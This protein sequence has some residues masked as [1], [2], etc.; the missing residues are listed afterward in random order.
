MTSTKLEDKIYVIEGIDGAG[1]GTCV[2]N[3]ANA[4]RAKK[5]AVTVVSF[6]QYQITTCGKRLGI[7][8]NNPAVFAAIPPFEKA[9]L[10]AMDRK[11]ACVDLRRDAEYADVVLVDRYTPSNMIYATAAANLADKRAV[12]FDPS[13]FARQVAEL[14]YD[15]L[16]IP[17]PRRVFV[18]DMP[19]NLA[20]KNVAAKPPRHYTGAT[21][22]ANE[23]N[24]SLL[25]ECSRLFCT[26]LANWHDNVATVACVTPDHKLRDPRTIAELVENTIISDRASA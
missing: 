9:L 23:S 1:K 7:L 10:F 19:V 18:L 4:L 22:D 24:S 14:E 16:Q 17:R 11:E 3:V 13:R 5:F 15:V 8:L 21:L 25:A 2:A 6:P 12:E 20:L 26:Q